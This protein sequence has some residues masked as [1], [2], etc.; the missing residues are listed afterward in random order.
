MA[1]SAKKYV[2]ENLLH[3][4][5]LPFAGQV[6]REDLSIYKVLAPRKDWKYSIPESHCVQK[7]DNCSTQMS[8]SQLSPGKERE[9]SRRR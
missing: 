7:R 4:L 5:T 6:N 9:K 2:P 1:T 8:R 3:L